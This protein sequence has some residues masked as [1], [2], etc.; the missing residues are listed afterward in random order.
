LAEAPVVEA[1]FAIAIGGEEQFPFP[2]D[3]VQQLR[4]VPA[5][6]GLLLL[7]PAKLRE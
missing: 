5:V 6:L 3:G 4:R 2:D 1:E 7:C